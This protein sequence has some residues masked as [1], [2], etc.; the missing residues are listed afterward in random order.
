MGVKLL[1]RFPV[2]PEYL[3]N[4]VFVIDRLVI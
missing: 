1:K 2:V 4:P 3:D